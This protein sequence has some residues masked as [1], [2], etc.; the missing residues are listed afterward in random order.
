MLCGFITY[1]NEA[2]HRMLGVPLDT[3]K[4]FGAVSRE[5]AIAMA[6]RRVDEFRCSGFC[7]HHRHRRPRRRIG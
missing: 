4:Q 3:L 5:T 1:S 2:K 7:F 6:A